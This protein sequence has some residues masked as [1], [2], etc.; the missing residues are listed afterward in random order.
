LFSAASKVDA[1]FFR[2]W[3]LKD[4][5]LCSSRHALEE[6]RFNL[7]EVNRQRRLSTLAQ[8]LHSREAPQR[9]LPEGVALPPK[10]AP[11]LLAAIEGRADYLTG[12]LHDFGPY[13]RRRLEGVVIVSPSSYFRIWKGA[14]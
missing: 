14:R 1:R 12:D 2:L 11:I 13:F 9:Q 7:A 3:Q 6:A 4:V 10:A 5:L 8:K